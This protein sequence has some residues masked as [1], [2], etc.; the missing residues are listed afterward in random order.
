M[1]IIK[2][3]K[4]S[5]AK[6]FKPSVSFFSGVGGEEKGGGGWGGGN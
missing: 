6:R 4:K 3:N 5:L 2:G 1:Q